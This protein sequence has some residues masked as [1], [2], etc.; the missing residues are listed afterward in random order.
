[1]LDYT[2]DTYKIYL[3]WLFDKIK[4]DYYENLLYELWKIEYKPDLELDENWVMRGLKLREEFSNG[5]NAKFNCPGYGRKVKDTKGCSVLEMLVSLSITAA[6]SVGEGTQW[7]DPTD[8][9]HAVIDNLGL[10]EATN[11]NSLLYKEL[12]WREMENIMAHNVEKLGG[13]Y[14]WFV[15]KKADLKKLA[16]SETVD[17][18][19]MD[20]WRQL[21]CWIRANSEIENIFEREEV[22]LEECEGGKNDEK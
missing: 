18:S 10:S 1:M 5:C 21:L 4:G 19:K 15:I 8:W 3:D 17:F 12:I 20:V 2:K 22:V 7:T 14:N 9:F 16:D 6:E 13:P 11:S